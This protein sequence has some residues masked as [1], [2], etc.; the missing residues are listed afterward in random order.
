MEIVPGIYAVDGSI[1]CNTYLIVDDGVTLVDTGLRGNVPR[2]YGSLGRIGRKPGDIKRIVITHAHLDHINCLD[3][4]KRETGAIVMA[5]PPTAEVLEGRKPLQAGLGA[6]AVVFRLLQAFYRYRPVP[7]DVRLADGDPVPGAFDFNAVYLPGH[8][9]GN[10]GL[11]S[12]LKRTL[13]S[14]D[15]ILS[16]EG[17][18]VGP[19]PRFTTDSEAAAASIRRAGGLDFDVLLPGHGPAVADGASTKVRELHRETGQ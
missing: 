1:G 6:L 12:R 14:S 19:R 16:S 18:P 10:M 3:R 15:A 13:I 8:S 11:F 17:R 7:V 4:L 5:S 2:I 9:E